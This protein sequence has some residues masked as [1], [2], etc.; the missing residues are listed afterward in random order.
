MANPRLLQNKKHISYHHQYNENRQN[1]VFT[2]YDPANIA[3]EQQLN[4]VKF[5]TIDVSV[6]DIRTASPI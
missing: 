5:F 1:H 6:E 2:H 4:A 3:G